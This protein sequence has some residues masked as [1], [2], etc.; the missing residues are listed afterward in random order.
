MLEFV[1]RLWDSAL[2]ST[3]PPRATDK[4]QVRVEGYDSDRAL[5]LGDGAAVGWGVESQDDALLGTLARELSARSGRGITVDLVAEPFMTAERAVSLVQD[6]Q[7]W[8]YD[9]VF[10][11]LGMSDATRL[12]SVNAWR[13]EMSKLLAFITE[14]LAVSAH[15]VVANIPTLTAAKRITWPFSTILSKRFDALNEAT[16]DLCAGLSRARYVEIVGPD[17]SAIMSTYAMIATQLAGALARV[18]NDEAHIEGA[19]RR[20]KPDSH[21]QAEPVPE[22]N[23][24]RVG[25]LVQRAF[26]IENASV[27]VLESDRQWRIDSLGTALVETEGSGVF[28][29][30][31][32]CCDDVIIVRDTH[33]D[34][35]FQTGPPVVGDS[36]IR[37]YA[38]FPI[39][40]PLG[41]RVGTLCI[42]HPARR[43]KSDD[44][45]VASLRQLAQI[46]LLDL[47]HYLP[48]RLDRRDVGG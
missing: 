10:I 16:L 48:P 25:K 26:R 15:I 44:V 20:L 30:S 22:D 47:W 12:T 35:R 11:L 46:A 9:Y 28:G 17:P 41:A 29:E 38:G 21:S 39:E 1:M 6:L 7:V 8:R 24:G 19:H 2:R 45:E 4:V 34:K 37:F 40:S 43:L 36:H 23:L 14:E 31:A 18:L 27:A 3:L 32:L 5:I 33:K 42:S 13:R